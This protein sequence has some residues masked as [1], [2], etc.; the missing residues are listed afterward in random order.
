MR[1]MRRARQRD[2]P[3]R[4]HLELPPHEHGRAG[5]AGVVGNGLELPD[6]LLVTRDGARL[7]REV[8]LED[9]D[10]VGEGLEPVPPHLR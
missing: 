10:G 7:A 5:A 6:R 1:P 2:L 4:V 3:G 8:E 9:R